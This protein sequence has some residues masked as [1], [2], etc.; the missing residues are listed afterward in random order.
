[1]ECNYQYDKEVTEAVFDI[2]DAQ[3]IVFVSGAE[4]AAYGIGESVYVDANDEFY[5]CIDPEKDRD[6][7]KLPLK[8]QLPYGNLVEF[9]ITK[10]GGIG[11]ADLRDIGRWAY[12]WDVEKCPIFVEIGET[13]IIVYFESDDPDEGCYTESEYT[14]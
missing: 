7:E 14:K 6:P 4:K 13:E 1:M 12:Q 2:A 9:T 11:I 3:L 10:D 8:K 5:I